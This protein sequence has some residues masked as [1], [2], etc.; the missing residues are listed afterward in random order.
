M[1]HALML[2]VLLPLFT[3]AFIITLA[4][5]QQRLMQ[6]IS[7]VATLLML[8]VAIYLLG[9]ANTGEIYHYAL[10]NWS[11][12]FGIILLLDRLS[13]LM[14]LLTAVLAVLVVLY[15]LRGDDQ[16]G[17]HFHALFQFQVAGIYGAFLTGDLFNLFVFFE[18]LLIASY[19]L[20]LHGRSKAQV[21]SAT[22]YVILN[23]VGSSLFLIA[24]GI[25][26]GIGGTLNMVDLARVV[27]AAEGDQRFLLN[28]AGCLLFIV[29]GLK[30][31]FLPL[32]F[33]LPKAY[34]SA[35]AS[36]A[37]LFAIMTKV[38]LYAVLRFSTLV[39]GGLAAESQGLGLS[40]LWVLGLLTLIIGALGAF[41]AQRLN[42]LIAYLVLVSV[43]TILAG[44]SLAT[45]ETTSATL[46]YLL[47]STLV[48]AGLFLL[49]GLISVQRGEKG[50]LL[51]RG[52]L[53]D[54]ARVL[55][56]MFFVG[57]ISVA[58]L[59]PFS[60][61]LGKALLLKYTPATAAIWLWPAVLMGGLLVIIALSRA[62]SQLFWRSN[63]AAVKVVTVD[64]KAQAVAITTLAASVLLVLFAEPISAYMLATAEQLFDVPSYFSVLSGG[65]AQ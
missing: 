57:A 29:F 4:N 39:F 12:P 28:A 30:A 62:G 43:G 47:H 16:K 61:F 19:A 26:Y 24:A 55:G 37:A 35:T 6:V 18:I 21:L 13:A 8:P 56:L 63:I 33:W 54:S 44:F 17:A 27:A 49:A 64:A 48:C 11:A 7:L 14:V 53:M 31:A 38:G 60:G 40:A 10:G 45:V 41:S 20:L 32:H 59:P 46:F 52:P 9:L 34:A 51:Q 50:D 5:Q 58:G 2:P 65:E 15:A 25:F 42:T 22:H 36:V 1:I 3:G 23:L